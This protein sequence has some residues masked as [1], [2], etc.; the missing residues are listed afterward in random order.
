MLDLI[1]K[2]PVVLVPIVGVL[3]LLAATAVAVQSATVAEKYFGK[4]D[5]GRI[6]IDEF[7][8]QWVALFLIPCSPGA[9]L[10]AFLLFRF[11]DIVKPFPAG[12]SQRLPGG[13]GV[14]LDDFFAGIYSNLTLQLLIYLWW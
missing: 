11:Y 6:V 4:K 7:V 12:R 8:G 10:A 9:V 5:D 2:K 14:V 1:K 3:F 13:V